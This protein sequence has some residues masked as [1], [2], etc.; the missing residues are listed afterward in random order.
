MIDIKGGAPNL[1]KNVV[2]GDVNNGLQRYGYHCILKLA[3]RIQGLQNLMFTS[4]EA[5]LAY[6]IN[7]QSW[8]HSQAK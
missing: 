1:N 6:S 5:T 8:K 7:I 2:N 3:P 4:A